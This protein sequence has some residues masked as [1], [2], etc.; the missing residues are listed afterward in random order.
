MKNGAGAYTYFKTKTLSFIKKQR[1]Y[2]NM[3]QIQ[4]EYKCLINRGSFKTLT[5]GYTQLFE[6]NQVSFYPG[7]W[8][9]L[10]TFAVDL[11]RTSEP[12]RVRVSQRQS[13]R[14]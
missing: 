8:D 2:L 10:R 14:S 5:M 9:K 13:R 7:F 11:Q 6:L 3:L 12:R 4:I 1:V